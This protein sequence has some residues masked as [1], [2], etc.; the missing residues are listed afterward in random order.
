MTDL[1][2]LQAR[3]DRALDQTHGHPEAMAYALGVLQE[4][5][6]INRPSRPGI[7]QYEIAIDR[8]IAWIPNKEN[9]R[10]TEEFNMPPVHPAGRDLRGATCERLRGDDIDWECGK[11]VRLYFVATAQ[12][13]PHGSGETRKHGVCSW[14]CA[15]TEAEALWGIGYTLEETAR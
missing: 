12:P 11:P 15:R 9:A 2:A 10:T 1:D 6:R 8:I 5:S 14:E 4:L 7:D 3:M 13:W